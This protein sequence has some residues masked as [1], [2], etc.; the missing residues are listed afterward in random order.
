MKEFSF[1]LSEQMNHL[2][3]MIEIESLRRGSVGPTDESIYY[4]LE[5]KNTYRIQHWK[6]RIFMTI[7]H[8]PE[9]Q[10]RIFS[11]LIITVCLLLSLL[12]VNGK[13]ANLRTAQ[14]QNKRGFP[15]D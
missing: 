12:M 9:A 4:V 8:N 14:V 7:P 11:E 10:Q 15:S 13:G 5:T 6:I 1:V 3:V 2:S